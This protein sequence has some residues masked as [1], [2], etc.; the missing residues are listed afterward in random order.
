MTKKSWDNDDVK[1]NKEDDN[2]NET[3]LINEEGK[4]IKINLDYC[5]VMYLNIQANAEGV[6][7]SY[8]YSFK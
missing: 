1:D 2:D 5:Q 6:K 4:V 7:V 8:E 3:E